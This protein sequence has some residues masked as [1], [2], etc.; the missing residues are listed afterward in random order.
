[1]SEGEEEEV[2]FPA[3]EEEA[4]TSVGAAAVGASAAAG[5][6]AAEATRAALP[7]AAERRLL[8]PAAWVQGA[9]VLHTPVF[10]V[11]LDAALP[12]PAAAAPREAQAA[13]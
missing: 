11:F 5:A 4:A 1:M 12:A 8:R 6:A 10:H 13:T 9:L 2:T 7:A 3:G